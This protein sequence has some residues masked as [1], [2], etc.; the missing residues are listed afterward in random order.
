V[1]R[2]GRRRFPD[3]DRPA[4]G[5]ADHDY[6]TLNEQ[7][8]SL[9]RRAELRQSWAGT[10]GSGTVELPLPDPN[11]ARAGDIPRDDTPVQDPFGEIF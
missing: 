8:V 2:A 3:G 1:R 4:G 7:S 10:Y 6:S 5:A 11:L 9:P